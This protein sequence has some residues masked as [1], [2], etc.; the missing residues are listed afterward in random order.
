M[1]PVRACRRWIPKVQP[2][3]IVHPVR[4][5][6]VTQIQTVQRY[7]SSLPVSLLQVCA[8]CVLVSL[9]HWTHVFHRRDES[10][11]F[12]HNICPLML[13]VP[14]SDLKDIARGKRLSPLRSLYTLQLIMWSHASVDACARACVCVHERGGE[15]WVFMF[16]C[17]YLWE[18]VCTDIW[19]NKHAN[20]PKSS[21]MGSVCRVKV[22]NTA[23][24]DSSLLSCPSSDVKEEEC[25]LSWELT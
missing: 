24:R 4:E 7:I 17:M 22:L 11:H 14:S 9:S 15:A 20:T 16:A 8:K 1:T 12:A 23:Y 19:P 10:V 21:E 2:L 5:A 13:R 25:P 3:A 6:G 18:Y